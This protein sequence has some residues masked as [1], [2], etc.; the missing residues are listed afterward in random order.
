M[1][2][3]LSLS[4]C[5]IFI[6]SSYLAA[7][8]SGECIKAGCLKCNAS[9]AAKCG[10]CTGEKAVDA[11]GAC[12]T[13]LTGCLKSKADSTT[14]CEICKEGFVGQGAADGTYTACAAFADVAS[15]AVTQTN[16]FNYRDAAGTTATA[17]TVCVLCKPGFKT[18]TGTPAIGTANNYCDAANTDANTKDGYLDA[19]TGS[20]TLKYCGAGFHSDG[21]KCVADADPL[22][23]CG[24]VASS[25][26][27]ECNPWTAS[28]ALQASPSDN[29]KCMAASTTTSTTSSKIAFASALALVGALVF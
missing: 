12:A 4:L 28:V 15:T 2:T 21:T 25:K 8:A 29:L 26:C 6:S 22:K 9:D 23:G 27:T 18:T 1:K 3:A 16:C 5:I 10:V 7:D 13:T 20:T 24:V 17:N 19:A 11:N 14:E